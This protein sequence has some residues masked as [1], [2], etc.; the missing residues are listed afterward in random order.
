MNKT[1]G[2]IGTGNIATIVL[3]KLTTLADKLRKIYVYDIDEDKLLLF[4]KKFSRIKYYT[5][6]LLRCSN[7]KQLIKKS[8][9]IMES[10][11]VGAVSEIL[12][13]IKPYKSKT[14]I[15]LSVGGLLENFD[16]YKL[17][18]DK[19]YRIKIPS[20]AIA[21]CD[22]LSAASIAGIRS[23]QLTTTKP[24][25]SLLNSQ[26][27]NLKP[28]LYKKVVKSTRTEIFN[29][30]VY[31]AV[32]YFPQ[33]INVAATLAIV[34]GCPEKVR[35]KIIADREITSNVHEISINS[36][37]GEIYVRTENVPS[38]NNPKTSYLAALSTL[39]LLSDVILH[40]Y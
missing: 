3:S 2:I 40:N 39:S 25:K 12:R 7:I 36:L 6:K 18:L 13:S 21:G 24:V 37:A 15:I 31:T 27:F 11:S 1:L 26:I 20:G 33:N 38:E 19:G 17:L 5:D 8:D 28:S 9:V 35:V 29:G 14:V 22:A 10:A 32:K 30:D 34:S 4:L 23:I 16:E